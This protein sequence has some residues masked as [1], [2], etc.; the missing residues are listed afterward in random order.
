MLSFGQPTYVYAIRQNSCHLQAQFCFCFSYFLNE[1]SSEHQN[2]WESLI[3][4]IWV[5]WSFISGMYK[6]KECWRPRK[7]KLCGSCGY[8]FEIKWGGGERYLIGH[9][10]NNTCF[11]LSNC[12]WEIFCILMLRIEFSQV[13]KYLMYSSSMLLGGGGGWL[14]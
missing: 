3:G 6:C 10:R 2:I 13:K 4:D 14:N 12:V 9:I 8:N 7:Q 5:L 11:G 1:I